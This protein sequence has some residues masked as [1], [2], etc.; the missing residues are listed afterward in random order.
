ML[1]LPASAVTSSRWLRQQRSEH[2]AKYFWVLCRD[3]NEFTGRQHCCYPVF[4][5]FGFTPASYYIAGPLAHFVHG[6]PYRVWPTAAILERQQLGKQVAGSS[7]AFHQQ[8][9]EIADET[10]RSQR[11]AADTTSR[12]ASAARRPKHSGVTPQRLW[13]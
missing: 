1:R 5:K 12:P 3:A 11:V 9:L 10:I 8:K 4:L 7:R 6:R 13:S 2:F